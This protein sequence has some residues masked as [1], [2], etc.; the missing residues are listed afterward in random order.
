MKN[1]L[2]RYAALVLAASSAQA[3]DLQLLKFDQP[4]PQASAVPAT[5]MR[6]RID[7]EAALQAVRTGG[8]WVAAPDGSRSY[9]RYVRH[10]LYPDGD[11]TWIGS[12]DTRYGKQSVVVTFGPDATFATIPQPRGA[13]LAV[14]TDRSGT[15]LSGGS[16]LLAPLR[17][18]APPN[19]HDTRVPAPVL[20]APLIEPAA[21]AAVQA[22]T[23][24]PIGTSLVDVMVAYTPGL[25]QRLGSTSNV[26]TRIHYLVSYANQAYLNSR[27]DMRLRLVRAAPVNYPD[28]T[29]N[30]DALTALTDGTLA[31]MRDVHGQR[32]RYGADLVAL[33]RPYSHDDSDGCGIGW[34]NGGGGTSLTRN[35]NATAEYGYS[36]VSDGQDGQWYCA[37]HSFAHEL[38]HNMGLAHDVANASDSGAFPYAYGYKR[39]VGSG[40]FSTIMA[41]GSAGQQDMQ[42]FSNPAISICQNYPCGVQN[43]ADNARALRQTNWLIGGFRH[44]RVAPFVV[45]G[46]TTSDVLWHNATTSRVVTWE[47]QGATHA[48]RPSQAVNTALRVLGVGDFDGDGFVDILWGDASRRLTM[49]RGGRSTYV[50]ATAGSYASGWRLV[51]TGDVDGDGKDD[52]L[53]Y[54]AALGR[55]D[56][57][58]MDG[59]AR[60]ATGGRY[61]SKAYRVLGVGDFNGDGLVDVAWGN[62]SRT[63]YVWTNNGGGSFTSTYLRTYASGGWRLR[64]VGDVD[65]DGKDDLLWHSASESRF[66]YWIMDGATVVTRHVFGVAPGYA[67]L[68]TGD[69]DGNGR[70][71]VLWGNASRTLYAWLGNGSTFTSTAAGT[72]SAGGWKPVNWKGV[73]GAD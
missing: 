11:W 31:A 16:T 59:T 28:N 47:M 58:L 64:G 6:V 7:E 65:G 44:T 69:F 18:E 62:A 56:Y 50:G 4:R 53:W 2:W 19:L 27:L 21:T 67:V 55:L 24:P 48:S 8:L 60:K 32:D 46:D 26:L 34:L 23:S 40:G 41:Y 43:Q 52:L 9:V 22:P 72:Y 37:D 38:G 66:V 35:F 13:S 10:E 39:T 68:A 45:D 20:R 61:A 12:V 25:V 73:T 63:V 3:A 51:G 14:Y 1:R 42:V 5:A 30:E 29:T 54:N 33:L 17:N 49:W 15:W 36:A 57:W 70:F 71:D